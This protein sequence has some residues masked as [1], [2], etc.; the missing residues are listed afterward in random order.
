ML[1]DYL[2]ADADKHKAADGFDFVF[3]EVPEFLADEHTEIR[4]CKCYQAYDYHRCDDGAC[5]Q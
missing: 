3:E 5:N 1:E 2:Y 4:E